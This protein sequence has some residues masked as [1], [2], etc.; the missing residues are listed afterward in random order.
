[1][2]TS[3]KKSTI[4][5]GFTLIELLVVIAIIGLLSSVIF[6]SLNTARAKARDTKKMA[7]LYQVFT[8]MQRYYLDT[9]STPTNPRAPSS[10]CVIGSGTCAQEIINATYL[11]VAP[12]SP[13]SD[14]YYYFD[15][16]PVVSLEVHL[17]SDTYGPST[18]GWHCSDTATLSAPGPNPRQYCL[19]FTK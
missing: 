2:D 11:P 14:P 6:A 9:N 16:G 4:R 12:V 10:Y 13:N 19:E 1:M 15:Y 7:E 3:E 18:Q 5:K 8:S 17:E